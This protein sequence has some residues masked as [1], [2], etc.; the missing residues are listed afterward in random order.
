MTKRRESMSERSGVHVGQ[1]R[2]IGEIVPRMTTPVPHLSCQCTKVLHSPR[3]R[4]GR[5][6]MYALRLSLPVP[7]RT[8]AH[9]PFP[10]AVAYSVSL[11][12]RTLYY[13]GSPPA[14]RYAPAPLARTL[15]RRLAPRSLRGSL[16][17]PR[18][19]TPA[20][21]LPPSSSFFRAASHASSSGASRGPPSH[22]SPE[23]WHQRQA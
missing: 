13:I 22:C 3:S 9:C 21:K 2:S 10:Q 17:A 5:F 1:V 16:T 23:K 4:F 19:R 8:V 18:P 12:P 20:V 6:H 7:P 11:S 14:S 15:A